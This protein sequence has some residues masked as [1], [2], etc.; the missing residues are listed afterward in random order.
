MTEETKVAPKQERV[1]KKKT[2]DDLM[3][4]KEITIFLLGLLVGVVFF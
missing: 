4:W 1:L 2:W 3:P